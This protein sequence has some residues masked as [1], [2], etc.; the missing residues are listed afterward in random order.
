MC[1]LGRQSPRDIN[2]GQLTLLSGGVERKFGTFTL[3]IGRFGVGLRVDRDILPR[4]HRHRPGHQTGDTRHENAVL[5]GMR[6]GDADHQAGGGHNA[7][8][9]P[10]HSRTQPADAVCTVTFNM[11]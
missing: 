3:K 5:A 2:A 1:Q 4:G 8:V 9:G 10:Q 7:V 11:A 6:G